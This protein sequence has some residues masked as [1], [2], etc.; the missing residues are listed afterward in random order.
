MAIKNTQ[1]T[2][3]ILKRI[4]SLKLSWSPCSLK[5]T[6]NPKYYDKEMLIYEKTSVEMSAT[7]TRF[8]ESN[9]LI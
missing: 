7:A 8:V 5:L 2:R 3:P 9:D 6:W 4:V 1:K